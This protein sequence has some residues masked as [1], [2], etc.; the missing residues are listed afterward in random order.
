MTKFYCKQHGNLQEASHSDYCVITKGHLP[1]WLLSLTVVGPN[2]MTTT[3]FPFIN[4]FRECLCIV[5]KLHCFF[6][7]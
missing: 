3:I 1:L 7:E 5:D 4:A 6:A 2:S